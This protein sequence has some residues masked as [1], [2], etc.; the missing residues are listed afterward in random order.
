MKL[1]FD[2]KFRYYTSKMN[3]ICLHCHLLYFSSMWT[4]TFLLIIVICDPATT[5]NGNGVCNNDGTC[6]CEPFFYGEYCISN[7]EKLGDKYSK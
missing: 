4:L 2:Y 7:L 1:I 5:C 6:Q 3:E